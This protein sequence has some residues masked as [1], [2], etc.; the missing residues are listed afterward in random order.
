VS[1]VTGTGSPIR[2]GGVPEGVPMAI[3]GAGLLASIAGI[4]SRRFKKA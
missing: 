3:G 2:E 4:L 1:I